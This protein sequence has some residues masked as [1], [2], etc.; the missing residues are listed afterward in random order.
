MPR[1][2]LI[3]DVVTGKLDVREAAAKLPE[4][5]PETEPVDDTNDLSHDEEELAEAAELEAEEAA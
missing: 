2:R 3:A 5:T 1:L 4:M